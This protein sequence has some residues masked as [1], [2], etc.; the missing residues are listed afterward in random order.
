MDQHWNNI[1]SSLR[2]C[3]ES[4]PHYDTCVPSVSGWNRL[5]SA[6]CSYG[7]KLVQ[8]CKNMN[9]VIINGR[10]GKDKNIGKPTC[11]D[12]S[13]VDYM[14]TSPELLKHIDNFE[15][16]DFDPLL[17]DVGL[18]CAIH[19]KLVFMPKLN[20]AENPVEP[21]NEKSNNNIDTTPSKPS[22][23]NENKEQYL[24]NLTIT[25]LSPINE[26]LHKVEHSDEIDDLKI[27]HLVFEISTLLKDTAKRSGTIFKPTRKHMKRKNV[28]TITSHDSIA[29][30]L[31]KENYISNVNQWK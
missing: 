11:R 10:C 21:N 1:G 19:T 27:N 18:H 29:T 28:K 16:N 8:F 17:S 14:I 26:L 30:V 7:P 3:W 12:V 23:K 6:L 13:V 20:S 25:D 9:L 22:W 15:K 4:C 5:H 31:E 24:P 2:V